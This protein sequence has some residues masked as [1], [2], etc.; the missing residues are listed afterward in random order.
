MVVAATTCAGIQQQS[1]QSNATKQEKC[2]LETHNKSSK[3]ECN[4][5]F[6]EV[7]KL[8]TLGKKSDSDAKHFATQF[9]DDLMTQIHL[10]STCVGGNL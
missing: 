9:D 8:V 1:T 4:K 3:L 6:N 5:N 7:Q 10:Q 2:A